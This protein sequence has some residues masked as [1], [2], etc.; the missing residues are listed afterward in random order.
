MRRANRPAFRILLALPF[1]VLLGMADA[2]AQE[3]AGEGSSTE[4]A[5]AF[6]QAELDQMLAPI[7]L[8]PDT[9][10][11]QILMAATYPLEVVQAAR[12]SRANRGLSGEQAIEAVEGESWDPSVKALVAVPQV[13]AMMDEKLEWTQ[14]LGDAFLAQ[15]EQVAE[16]V[17]SLRRRAYA[18]GRLSSSARY[19]V[20]HRDGDIVIEPAEPHVVYVPY[21][22]PRV[23]YGPWWWAGYPPVYWAP[24]PGYY[25]YA[26]SGF[27]WSIG[28]F[29][30]PRFFFSV[31]DWPHRHIKVV[32]VHRHVATVQ[33]KKFVHKVWRHDPHHRHGVKYRHAFTEKKFAKPGFRHEARRDAR[34][35]DPRR[36]SSRVVER[37]RIA[38]RHADNAR[39]RTHAGLGM[40]QDRHVTSRHPKLPQAKAPRSAPSP[41]LRAHTIVRER[42]AERHVA[43]RVQPPRWRIDNPRMYVPPKVRAASPPS[44]PR[45]AGAAGASG[46]RAA[47]RSAPVHPKVRNIA[48]VPKAAFRA[49]SASGR[50]FFNP[51]FSAR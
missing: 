35:H 41:K 20:V 45:Y 18:A 47:P 26:G 31:W 32:H 50:G 51:K 42:A 38:P 14:D 49:P 5:T 3:A 33:P 28:I 40:R 29:V 1:V 43:A 30:G 2:Y 39:G 19:R 17:Q 27:H 15:P 25:A 11:S 44:A 13:L 46:F 12:W 10:L 34:K 6:S 21:Y 9:L 8:Y 4:T 7:A 22:D 36:W 37:E 48:P 16:T 23:V 24:W